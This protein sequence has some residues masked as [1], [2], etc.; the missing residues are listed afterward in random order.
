MSETPTEAASAPA[1][2]DQVPV[3][4]ALSRV[5]RDVQAVAKKD[6]NDFQ[7][8]NFRGIDAV[9]NAVGPAF[10]NHGVVCLPNVVSQERWTDTTKQNGTQLHVLLEVL[11]TFIGPSG[12]T[13]T[14]TT[15]GEAF[16][17]GDKAFSK[18][19]SVAYRTCLL[20]ALCIPTDEPD[21]D[22]FT[23]APVVNPA[24]VEFARRI[25]AAG[26]PVVLLNVATSLTQS[27]RRAVVPWGPD[28]QEVALHDIILAKAADLLTVTEDTDQLRALHKVAMGLGDRDLVQ[29]IRTK[30]G[31]AEKAAEQQAKDSA[32]ANGVGEPDEDTAE[33][34]AGAGMPP[35]EPVVDHANP[36]RK[37]LIAAFVQV[38]GPDGFEKLT[39][40]ELGRHP[41]KVTTDEL[42]ALGERALPQPAGDES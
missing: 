14:A 6:R 30:A 26:E 24:V 5:M 8:F 4:V 23:S 9:V 18:A 22:S 39:E 27:Q 7:K 33:P 11:F 35:E 29:G 12:D 17:S 31:A 37:A 3:H 28:G 36:R 21:P 40:Q 10:R 38:F 1:E 25:D 13:L 2:P 32:D 15:Y 20:Q 16:D 42:H 34:P 41:N 19:H